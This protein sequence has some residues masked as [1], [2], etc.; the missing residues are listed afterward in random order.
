MKIDKCAMEFLN[1]KKA[2][3]VLISSNI[4]SKRVAS[5]CVDSV[6]PV[7][8]IIV[9]YGQGILEGKNFVD[10]VYED[11]KIYIGEKALEMLGDDFT[12]SLKEGFLSKKLIIKD[13]KEI[14]L[15]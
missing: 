2:E 12:I 3:Y 15:G 9:D 11:K 1:S 4:K 6:K 8:E 13:V 7:F 14:D 10:K 5:C